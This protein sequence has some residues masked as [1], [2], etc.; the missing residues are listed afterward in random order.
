TGNRLQLLEN[1][2]A[3]FPVLIAD[4]DS[5]TRACFLE[6]YIWSVGGLAEEVGAAL[7]RAV[8]RGVDCRVLVDALGSGAFLKSRQCKELRRSGVRVEAAMGFGLLRLVFV[9][10]DLRMHRKIG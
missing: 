3:A 7:V 5:A 4:I 2:N 1:A 10:P 6:F 9:R 8:K